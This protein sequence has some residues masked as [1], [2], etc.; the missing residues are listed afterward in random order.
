MPGSSRTSGTTALI[1]QTVP[2]DWQHKGAAP[3][4]NLLGTIRHTSV[5]TRLTSH[6]QEGIDRLNKDWLLTTKVTFQLKILP[7][8]ATPI[9]RVTS[10]PRNLGSTE[11]RVRPKKRWLWL[12]TSSSSSFTTWVAIESRQGLYH[13][14]KMI[15]SISGL[16]KIKKWELEETTVT[17][18]KITC[19]PMSSIWVLT[20]DSFN[21]A[22]TN[23]TACRNKTECQPIV[24]KW[25]SRE[26]N[27]LSLIRPPVTWRWCSR[28]L[29]LWMPRSKARPSSRWRFNRLNSR[30]AKTGPIRKC[31]HKSGHS[32][33][34]KKRAIKT[35]H[36]SK[37]ART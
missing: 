23:Q 11:M 1:F 7:L 30:W 10:L 34:S 19:K 16:V 25:T 27:T 8:T 37:T 28:A 14:T 12:K 18:R 9:T 6:L 15:K 17:T 29:F 33:W 24:S 22:T 32:I 4:S 3:S 13:K 2:L 31:L 20:Q 5:A 21:S 35:W 36:L 26:A